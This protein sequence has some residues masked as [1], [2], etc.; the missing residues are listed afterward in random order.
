[1]TRF[2]IWFLSGLMVSL[3]VLM[4][5]TQLWD[6]DEPL[7]VRTGIEM[8][9]AGNLLLPQFN[10]EVFAHKPP[11]GY[12]LM[13]LASQIFGHTE[14]AA[15]VLSAPAL[16]LSVWLIGRSGTLMFTRRV[17]EAAMVIAATGFMSI[18][19]GAAAMMDSFLLAGYSLC[20]WV[21]LKIITEGRV[22][23]G[24]LA[25]FALG[26]VQTML[27]KGPVG[28]ALIGAMALGAFSFLPRDERPG[29]SAFFSLVVAGTVAIGGFLMWFIPANSASGGAL[30]DE[31]IG[32]HIVGRALSPM[33]GHGGQGVVGFLLFLP[34]YIPVILLGMIPWTAFLPASI[35]HLFTGMPRRNRV[36]LLAWFLPTFLAFSIVATKL[37]HYIF[38]AFA[39]LSVAIAAWLEQ[40]TGKRALGG[41]ILTSLL[42]FLLAAFLGWAAWSFRGDLSSTLVVLAALAF[43]AMSLIVWRV[44][45]SLAVVPPL[46]LASVAVMQVFYWGGLREIE[47]LAKLSRPLGQA[48]QAHAPADAPV[49]MGRYREPS[50]V[51]YASRPV[52]NAIRPIAL[53]GLGEMV[54]EDPVGFAVLTEREKTALQSLL[55]ALSVTV[56][57]QQSARNFNQNGENQTVFLLKWQRSLD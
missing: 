25:L 28:P 27:V 29:W 53:E 26:G 17:G 20:V 54:A 24:L 13:G 33:E 5:A 37:P 8:F 36:L 44:K 7:Y 51:F 56:L 34:V 23:F 43:A 11:F 45:P 50:L 2:E 4:P 30:T 12:W 49:Y 21:L 39:P 18:Y 3:W 14:F 32:I 15:R 46:A 41:R 1:M 55:P 57:A 47:S 19:L 35:R 48:I 9:E 40:S 31:G 42:Y 6:W 10:G 52:D 16:A 22:S 38:P